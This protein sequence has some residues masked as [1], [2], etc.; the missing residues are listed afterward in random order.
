MDILF[1]VSIKGVIIQ[2]KHILLLQN[3]RME[4][5]LPG[6]RLEKHETPEDCV[7][8]EVQ[9]ELGLTCV[10][11]KILNTWVY[12]VL[13]NKFVFIVTYLCHLDKNTNIRISEEHLEYQWFSL[14][15]VDRINM[16]PGYKQSIQ[17]AYQNSP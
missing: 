8:R 13:P 9:E 10:L 2:N 6:G 15:D 17:I 16:P 4:W 7:I 11:G 1:P 3:E 12:E 5:E 14:K